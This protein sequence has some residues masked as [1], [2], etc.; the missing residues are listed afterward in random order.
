MKSD[1]AASV[2]ECIRSFPE[3]A[4]PSLAEMRALLRELVPEGEWRISYRM[5]A[6]FLGGRVVAYFAGFAHHVGFYPGARAL[7]VFGPELGGYRHAKGSIQFPLGA[8]L[9]RELI[10]R[11]VRFKVEEARAGRKR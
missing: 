1:V 9:P 10:E 3:A 5:P 6:L 2:D 8:P 7:E 11:I 4:Q